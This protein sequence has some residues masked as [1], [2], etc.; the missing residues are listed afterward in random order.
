MEIEA[1]E[2]VREKDGKRIIFDINTLNEY[3]TGLMFKDYLF[4]LV[5]IIIFALCLVFQPNPRFW[6]FKLLHWVWLIYILYLFLD[7]YI[8]GYENT[9]NYIDQLFAL[10]KY[11]SA[12]VS[13]SIS[14]QFE[15]MPGST[16]YISILW[17]LVKY[18]LFTLLI[19]YQGWGIALLIFVV[20][21][22]FIEFLPVNVDRHLKNIQDCLI[23][24]EYYSLPDDKDDL[25]LYL[26]KKIEIQNLISYI[27][28]DERDMYEILEDELDKNSKYK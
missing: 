11:K 6:N 4:Y 14:S 27:L 28:E 17:I 5:Y 9:I 8:I 23:E 19:I 12:Q 21:S 3:I 2:D 24:P 25:E 13:N 10:R 18:I 26:K 20:S 22:I 15:I 1:Y 16:L 7:Y